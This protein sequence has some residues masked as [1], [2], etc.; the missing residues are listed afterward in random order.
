MARKSPEKEEMVD[1]TE[2]PPVPTAS[3]CHV[4]TNFTCSAMQC[5]G[6]DAFVQEETFSRVIINKDA[7][8]PI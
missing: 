4:D 8:S 2:A 6:D 5:A 7:S 3:S 1:K